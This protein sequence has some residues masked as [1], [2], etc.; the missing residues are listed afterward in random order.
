MV[1]TE[2]WGMAEGRE[3]ERRRRWSRGG[4]EEECREAEK[5]SD[6]ARVTA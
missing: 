3:R 5:R 2:G 4:R 1:E 6:H